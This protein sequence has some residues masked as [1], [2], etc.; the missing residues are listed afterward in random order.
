MSQLYSMQKILQEFALATAV[1]CKRQRTQF[2]VH[3]NRC[4]S[5]WQLAVNQKI[6]S[7]CNN[8]VNF[9]DPII[10][11][12][13]QVNDIVVNVDS[14]FFFTTP[15]LFVF[16]RQRNPTQR[17]FPSRIELMVISSKLVDVV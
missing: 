12:Q 2:R 11:I 9:I 7:E 17:N 13:L 8:Q 1:C 3:H 5:G 4:F 14:Y 16:V 15:E 10:R 6:D